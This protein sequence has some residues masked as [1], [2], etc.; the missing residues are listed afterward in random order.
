MEE[1]SIFQQLTHLL[2]AN[3]L[4]TGLLLGGLLSLILIVLNWD[5]VRY[6][7]MRIWHGIPVIGSVSRLARKARVDEASID[8]DG[9]LSS[10]KTLCEHYYSYYTNVD[11]DPEYFRKCEDY[12]AKVT[13]SGRRTS[14]LWV[15]PLSAFLLVLEAVGFAY[16]LGPFISRE[17]SA[18]DLQL[19]T[20]SVASFLALIS[21]FLA[22]IAGHQIH[23]NSLVKK[24]R[25]W[26]TGDDPDTR[27]RQI[28]HVK[29]LTIDSTYQDDKE[30]LY[31]QILARI[32]TNT[33]VTPSYKWIGLFVGVIIFIAIA[34]FW[35]R[36]EQLNALETILI[37]DMKAEASA[38]VSNSSP[39]ELPAESAAINAKSTDQTI[40]DR[41]EAEHR[42]SLIT[43]VVLSVIYVAI[44]LIALWLGIVYGFVG[45]HSKKA[46]NLTSRFDNADDMKR[47]ME[48]EKS[49]ICSHANHKLRMLQHIIA[50]YSVSSSAAQASQRSAKD[51]DFI[52]FVHI[53]EEQKLNNLQ[54]QQQRNQLMA[55]SSSSSIGGS[56]SP[57]TAI[58]KVALSETL[59]TIEEG[60]STHTEPAT[61]EPPLPKASEFYDLRS[62]AED[63]LSL[64]TDEFDLSLQQ[65]LKIQSM[66]LALAKVGRFPKQ[67]EP[68]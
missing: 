54:R 48:Q 59:A 18:N 57:A 66:Q 31:N 56:F 14:P 46:Y 47:W 2:I 34:A 40:T 37:A 58:P 49:R 41:I 17:I 51:R 67:E 22:H 45:H 30:K 55:E 42:A 44:Q 12:L 15:I 50:G 68:A 8:K 23:H 20:W 4:A 1:L 9:W 60:E 16:V 6:T 28:G 62:L 35:I 13:E 26:W 65:L 10:E 24:A 32:P 36:T 29:P 21:G 7:A 52:S 33:D 38:Q 43:F 5:K 63:E 25:H 19:L 53:K 39:F 3:Q 11:K 64:L 27:D 61:S